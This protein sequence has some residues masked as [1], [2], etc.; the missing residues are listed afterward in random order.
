MAENEP[1]ALRMG[2]LAINKAQD[3][4]G[5][6][7]NMEAAFADFMVTTFT[8]GGWTRPEE[9]RLGGVDLALRGLR[10]ERAGLSPGEDD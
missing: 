4:Q 6:S 1:T 3:A 2:K 5:F 7:A 8:A 9:R 10:G